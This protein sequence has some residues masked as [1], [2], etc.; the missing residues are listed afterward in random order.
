MKPM[1][2][3]YRW[4][5]QFTTAYEYIFAWG[6]LVLSYEFAATPPHHAWLPCILQQFGGDH[7]YQYSTAWFSRAVSIKV[8]ELKPV[9]DFL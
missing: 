8:W 9:S 3:C 1:F 2:Q 5:N 6:F 4:G 7:L